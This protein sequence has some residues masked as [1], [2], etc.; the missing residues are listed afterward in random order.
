MLTSYISAQRST[1]SPTRLDW[2]RAGSLDG[3]PTNNQATLMMS[4]NN[5]LPTATARGNA[6]TAPTV[7]VDGRLT[8]HPQD[9]RMSP[10]TRGPTRTSA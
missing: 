5:Y 4:A 7:D 10:A 8:S 1:P 2:L 9:R 6:A 3:N